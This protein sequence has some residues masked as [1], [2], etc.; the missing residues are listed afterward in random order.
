[1]MQAVLPRSWKEQF[2]LAAAMREED[3]LHREKL[4]RVDAHQRQ[5]TAERAEAAKRQEAEARAAFDT[6]FAP[7]AKVAAFQ[8]QLDKYDTHTV[9]ALMENREALDR[10]RER[11]DDMLGKAH[12]L[13]DG[14]RVFKT[15]DGESVFDQHG[16]KLGFE[17]VDPASI[18]D[19]KPKWEKFKDLDD[20]R[21]RLGQERQGLVDYQGKLDKAREWLDGGD[22]TEA[23]LSTMQRDLRDTMPEAVRR[24]AGLDEQGP[25]ATAPSMFAPAMPMEM[26]N[27][28]RQTGFGQPSAPGLR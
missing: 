14:R 20:E 6:A 18:A 5:K 15:M 4:A 22:I 24:K 21:A 28:M 11:L 26:D 13:P 9:E 23:E 7:P 8:I 16:A 19:N 10:V 2:A 17:E 27:L 25:R 1:M 12:V 3:I